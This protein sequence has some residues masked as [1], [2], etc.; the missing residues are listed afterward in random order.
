M[1]I[2]PI[3]EALQTDA[4]DEAGSSEALPRSFEEAERAAER[5]ASF[6]RAAAGLILATGLTA[7]IA[8][9]ADAERD[10]VL[11][12]VLMA[13][14]IMAGFVTLA[15]VSF[16]ASR[17]QRYHPM[18]A[19]L[20]VLGDALIILVA[21]HEGMRYSGHQGQFVFAQ[22]PVWLIPI[23]IAIQSVRFR[24]GPL[25]LAAT[26]FLAVL[27]GLVLFA[28]TLSATT[29]PSSDMVAL[30]SVPSDAIR[31]LMLAIASTVLVV[32]VRSKRDILLKG[33]NTA[34]REAELSRFLPAEVSRT[35]GRSAAS[36]LAGQRVLAI[37]FLDLTGFTR[38]SERV[39][40]AVVAGWLAEFRDRT[41]ALIRDNGGFVDKFIGDGVMAIFG[42]RCEPATAARQALAVVEAL[43]A[44]MAGWRTADP[45]APAFQVAAG[46][47][48]GPV[49]V[50]VIGAGRRREFTVV[51]DAVNVAA[52]LEGF[53]KENDA[54]AALNLTLVEAAR[55]KGNV[56]GD[57]RQAT[58][59]GHSEPVDVC[60]IGRR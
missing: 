3:P 59:R 43:P 16:L 27:A 2:G 42:Y 48:M 25:I 32:S 50:G 46:G 29:H 37:L 6:A 57:V 55:G 56:P 19:Y 52:R 18:L 40:P 13:I 53:A 20:F 24:T 47:S 21:L 38:E 4:E 35:L 34:R 31:G 28:G 49:F 15:A 8:F 51:G 11:P 41:H 5:I 17:T 12:R 10:T 58:I 22:P 26:L 39:E 7:A 44:T 14:G 33:M 30:F 45:S 36:P 60:V 23:A 54:L 9:I 1:R